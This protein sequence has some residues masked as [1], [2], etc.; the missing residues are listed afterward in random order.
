LY[1]PIYGGSGDGQKRKEPKEKKKTMQRVTTI[2]FYNF[3]KEKITSDALT[4]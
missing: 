2:I 3:L 1:P 4:F